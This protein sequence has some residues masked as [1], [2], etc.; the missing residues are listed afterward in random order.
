MGTSG[1]PQ[2][3]APCE[4]GP[5]SLRRRPRTRRLCSPACAWENNIVA[6]AAAVLF[7]IVISSP[8][9]LPLVRFVAAVGQL[10]SFASSSLPLV[11][12]VAAVRR[13][14]KMIDYEDG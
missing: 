11:R 3:R 13:A 2:R 1:P 5:R 4:G 10:L 14:P 12:F 9:S 8:P 7:P 6:I